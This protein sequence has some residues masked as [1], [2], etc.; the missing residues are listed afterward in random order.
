MDTYSA[1][2][3]SCAIISG[4]VGDKQQEVPVIGVAAHL[5]GRPVGDRGECRLVGLLWWNNNEWM[6]DGFKAI[7]TNLKN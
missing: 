7:R 6:L 3:A 1:P 4:Q 2:H 5:G